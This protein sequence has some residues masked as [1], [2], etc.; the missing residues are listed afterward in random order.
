MSS[1]PII[2]TEIFNYRITS[3]VEKLCTMFGNEICEIGDQKYFS[4]PPVEKLAGNEIETKLRN[5]GFGYRAKYINKSA[6]SIVANGGNKWFEQLKKDDYLEA[7][8]KLCEL[9]GIGAKVADCICLMSL[10]HLEAVPID[11]HVYKIAAVHYLPHL[12]N[13]KSVTD[14]MYME[15]G[16]HFREL[17]G[18]LAGWA[19]TVSYKSLLKVI[20]ANANTY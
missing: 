5:A 16:N 3:L 20:N 7:K 15:I 6:E 9:H 18:D 1:K 19:H 14:K 13:K 10:G 8:R 11:T 17:F 2:L 4:F 12:R